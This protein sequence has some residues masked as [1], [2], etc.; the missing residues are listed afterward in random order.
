MASLQA[1]LKRAIEV[2]YQLEDNELAAGTASRQLNA[3]CC[4]SMKRR[5]A[6]RVCLRRLVDEPEAL[7]KVARDALRNLSL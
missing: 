7:A 5:K 4:C 1:A 6:A 3:A 2:R